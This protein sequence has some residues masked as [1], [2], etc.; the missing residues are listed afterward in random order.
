MC[1]SNVCV[2]VIQ[3]I[4]A[5]VHN[6]ELLWEL[7]CLWTHQILT[8]CW[9]K[10]NYF[11]YRYCCCSSDNQGGISCWGP[12]GRIFKQ[13]DDSPVVCSIVLHQ[14]DFWEK[15]KW[16]ICVMPFIQCLVFKVAAP[17]IHWKND[18]TYI[19]AEQHWGWQ[20]HLLLSQC[21]QGSP[22]LTFER[23]P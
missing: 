9:T 16:C 8:F 12:P 21:H 1:S 5:R 3:Y 18:I 20:I 14:D 17:V 6:K 7:L 4:I 10:F 2:C 15:W 19:S 11:L 13:A 23:A 22:L